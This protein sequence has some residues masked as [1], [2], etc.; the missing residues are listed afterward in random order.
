MP[1][2]EGWQYTVDGNSANARTRTIRHRGVSFQR[3]CS[4]MKGPNCYNSIVHLVTE[5]P[6]Y[7]ASMVPMTVL[8]P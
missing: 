2:D 8:G 5:C 6:V 1:I 7:V 4:I 3:R